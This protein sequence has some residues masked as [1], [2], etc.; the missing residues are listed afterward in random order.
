MSAMNVHYTWLTGGACNCGFT[1]SEVG[2]FP[3]CEEC[4]ILSNSIVIPRW[5]FEDYMKSLDSAWRMPREWLCVDNVED[6]AIEYKKFALK[7][8][9]TTKNP[10]PCHHCGQ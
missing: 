10:Q 9:L 6:A 7:A 3:L 8:G 4:G 5:F 2:F 1:F